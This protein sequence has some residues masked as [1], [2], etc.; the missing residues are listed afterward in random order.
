MNRYL[1]LG[2]L[3]LFSGCNRPID[4]DTIDPKDK[5]GNLAISIVEDLYGRT[6]ENAAVARDAEFWHQQRA[7]GHA[8]RFFRSGTDEAKLFDV[9][10]KAKGL[11]T[12]ILSNAKSGKIL[13]FQRL[14]NDPVE[15]Q[16]LISKYEGKRGPPIYEDSTGQP[17]KLGLI[18]ATDAQKKARKNLMGLGAF[19]E[20][21]GVKLIPKEQWVDIEVPHWNQKQY[22]IDQ[23][24]TSSCVGA[25]AAAAIGKLMEARGQPFQLQSGPFIYAHINGGRDA[26]AYIADAFEALKKYGTVP[27]KSFNYPNLYLRQIPSSVKEDGLKHVLTAGYLIDTEA[28]MATA[29]QM[30]LI[31]Q[32]GVQVDGNFE[33]FDSNGI[34]S[35]RGRYANHSI[36]IDGMKKIGGEWVYHM[37]NTWGSGWGPFRNGSCYLRSSGVILA[38]EAFA[39]GDVKWD[40]KDLPVIKRNIQTSSN[41]PGIPLDVHKRSASRLVDHET[42][43]VSVNENHGPVDT[44]EV[45]SRGLER[46]QGRR[47]ETPH[48]GRTGNVR[49]PS[50]YR[51]SS[52]GIEMPVP[53]Q[54]S[55]ILAL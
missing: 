43:S 28:E 9:Q 55:A 8:V 10:V 18:P 17:R 53:M 45:P 35:A 42:Q 50:G 44:S 6:P 41:I 3:I 24:S 19:L 12:I 31:V 33:R 38:G 29:L 48:S 21:S 30:G 14:S 23:G 7:N 52:K 39:H 26:G 34:S 11:P 1:L 37:P 54:A 46:I 20:A 22:V 13:N 27:A 15:V 16:K 4:D 5:T 49:F 2:V 51:Q 47:T 25:S 40:A 36:H 32:A